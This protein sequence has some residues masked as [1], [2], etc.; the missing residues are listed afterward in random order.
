MKAIIVFPWVTMNIIVIVS[1]EIMIMP[2]PFFPAC[3]SI[4]GCELSWSH[5][6]E[7][8]LKQI[9][10][11]R[12]RDELAKQNE[13]TTELT[14]KLD[15]VSGKQ[16]LHVW[17]FSIILLYQRLTECLPLYVGNSLTESSVGGSK[18]WCHQI[19][20]RYH[21]FDIS[22]WTC[23]SPYRDVRRT[24]SFVYPFIYGNPQEE[25]RFW[26]CS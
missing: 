16:W 8:W 25:D 24:C 5:V 13:E 18:V 7:I 19:L 20:H 26:F 21:R 14:T 17:A 15:K 6:Y 4:Y 1:G 10:S 3:M 23:R 12:I 9:C 22:R 2:F 11:R